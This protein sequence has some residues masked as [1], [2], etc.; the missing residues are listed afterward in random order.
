MRYCEGMHFDL[1]DRVLTLDDEHV[2]TLKS[3]TAAEEYLRDH[4][5]SFPVLPGVLMIEAMVQAARRLLAHRDG[6][7]ARHVLGGV[8]ALKYGTFV[9]PGDTMRVSVSVHK[10]GE[11]GTF[12]MK[13]AAEIVSSGGEA[14]DPPPTCVSGRFV[15]RPVA[16]LVPM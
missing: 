6:A 13:G 3:V 7:N 9:K 4:F 15:M 2:V 10:F 12:Q 11:D 16:A 5:P 1:V 8:R 14:L